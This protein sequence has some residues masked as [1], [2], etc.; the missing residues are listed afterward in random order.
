MSDGE[1]T[2]LEFE[3]AEQSTTHLSKL[4][5]QVYFY[6]Q[7]HALISPYWMVYSEYVSSSQS[8]THLY[9]VSFQM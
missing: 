1:Q 4:T 6:L 9:E 7:A 5:S 8:L 2:L 3:S